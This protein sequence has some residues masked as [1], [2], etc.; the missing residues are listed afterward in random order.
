MR[1]LVKDWRHWTRAERVAAVL[2]AA[3]LVIG[4]PTAVVLNSLLTTPDQHSRVEGT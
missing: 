2:L 1:D 4:V 3:T